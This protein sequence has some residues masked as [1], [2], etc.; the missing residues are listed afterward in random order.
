MTRFSFFFVVYGSDGDIKVKRTQQVTKLEIPVRRSKG[1]QGD[2]TV[3]WSLYHNDSSDIA[4]LIWPSSGKLSMADGQWNTFFI[5]SIANNRK[6]VPESVV[7][8]QLDDA[9]GGALLA[10]RNQTTAKMVIA[11]TL[12]ED[13]GKRIIIVV[14]VCV[15]SVI[16]LLAV[17][18]CIRSYKKKRK[19]YVF[20]FQKKR[21]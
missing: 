9:T 2:I 18:W 10:S 12:R 17:F 20:F 21:L 13:H 19:R 7:W 6:E 15:V 1:S 3:Q 14:S 8:V 16:V 11:S 4:D 5:I